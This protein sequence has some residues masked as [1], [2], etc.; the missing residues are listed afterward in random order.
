[1]KTKQDIEKKNET[2]KNTVGKVRNFILSG[3]ILHIYS[4]YYVFSKIDFVEYINDNVKY[5]ILSNKML[6][7]YKTVILMNVLF[8]VL[9]YTLMFINVLKL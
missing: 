5:Y 9:N 2:L 6:D 4:L 1:M 8:L 7:I 3:V